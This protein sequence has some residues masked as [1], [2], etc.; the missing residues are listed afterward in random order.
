VVSALRTL[1]VATLS[2]KYMLSLNIKRGGWCTKFMID[3]SGGCRRR[4]AS[5]AS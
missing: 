5:M 3:G 4:T 1:S 2:S